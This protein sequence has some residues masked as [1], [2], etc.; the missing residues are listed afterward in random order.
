MADAD[1]GVIL[2]NHPIIDWNEYFD[3]KINDTIIVNQNIKS[4]LLAKHPNINS[5]NVIG[6]LDEGFRY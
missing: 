5:D 3:P 1:V 2:L 4:Q 6:S